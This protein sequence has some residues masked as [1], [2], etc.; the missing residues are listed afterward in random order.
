MDKILNH[1]IIPGRLPSD[2]ISGRIPW[3]NRNPSGIWYPYLVPGEKQY[4]ST[5]DTMS[6]VSFAVNNAMEI[7]L[8][9]YGID[10]NFSDRFLATL[11]G[12][13][14]QGNRV[15]TV[16]DTFKKFGA[17]DESIWPKPAE[18]TTWESYMSP[19]SKSVINKAEKFD[20][21]Y[22]YLIDP[23]SIYG[24]SS[25]FIQHELQHAP[26]LVTIPG[27]EVTAIAIEGDEVTILDDYI[28]NVDPNQPFIRKIKLSDITDIYKAVLTVKNMGQFKTQDKNGEFRIVL[29]ASSIEEWTALCKVYGVDPVNISE[30]VQDK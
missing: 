22:E 21:Q 4:F 3:E 27:H 18:P 23:T 8:K 19:V 26:L 25:A 10:R 30:H 12:T 9:A 14:K 15:S 13:T 16:L 11:S 28:F 29:A 5:F 24:Y 1:G 2:W 17:V 6:C 20:I 7:Q